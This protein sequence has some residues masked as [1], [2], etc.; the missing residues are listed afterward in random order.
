MRVRDK[1]RVGGVEREKREEIRGWD[2]VGGC[3][4]RISELTESREK[5]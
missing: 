3:V 5:K 2:S 4:E 1:G